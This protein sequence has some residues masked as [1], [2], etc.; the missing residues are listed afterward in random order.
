MINTTPIEEMTN[1][2]IYAEYKQ[3]SKI[4]RDYDNGVVKLENYED[5]NK[6]VPRCRE[7]HVHMIGALK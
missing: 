3:V 6:W 7:L 2:E 1:E 4:I 5:R